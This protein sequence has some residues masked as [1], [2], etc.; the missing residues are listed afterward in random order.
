MQVSKAI[1]TDLVLFESACGFEVGM[2]PKTLGDL[3][4]ILQRNM[5]PAFLLLTVMNEV[6]I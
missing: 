5:K 1:K 6:M 3:K 4:D 2:I